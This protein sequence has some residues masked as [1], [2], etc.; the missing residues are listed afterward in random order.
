MDGLT[1][2]PKRLQPAFLATTALLILR[3][4]VS[5][6]VWGSHGVNTLRVDEPPP[7]L[8]GERTLTTGPHFSPS[9][10]ETSGSG[11]FRVWAPHSPAGSKFA[12]GVGIVGDSLSDEYRFFAP[13]RV[14]ARNW[15]E[16]LASTRGFHFGD[17]TDTGRR[18]A[19]DRRFAYNWSQSGATTTS[20][21]ARG[22]HTGLAA[23]VTEGAAV[24]LVAVT[25]G[26]NDFADVLFRSRSVPAMESVLEGASSN[27]ATILDAL[28][29]INRELRLAV[30]TA[31]DL[32]SSP[33]LRAALRSGLIPA[34]LSDAYGRAIVAFND[35]LRDL[36]TGQEHRLVVVDI[37]QL[38]ID[39]VM[40]RRYAVGSLELD[41]VNGGNAAQHLFLSDGFHPGTIGQCLIANEFLVAINSRFDAG[42]PLL[43]G[44]EM[45]RI[46]TSV[47]RPSGLAL[48]GT[49]VLA[50]F[51]YGRRRPRAA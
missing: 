25:V 24:N 32:R 12:D 42:V 10:P 35:R 22:Q 11:G 13:D 15:V 23:Q 19:E 16:I 27:L 50:L 30:F 7:H 1:M 2:P 46:A 45:V 40:A 26:T 49:G 6:R 21:L 29:R 36:A 8:P 44:D 20:L 34:P 14:T 17:R 4:L 33:L 5:E 37:N 41:R 51:G 39:V 48:I 9:P 47:S 38:L 43:G 3:H 28:L 31:A 18:G